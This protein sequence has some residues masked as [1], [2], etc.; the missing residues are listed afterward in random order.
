MRL[1][2]SWL[3]V[4]FVANSFH[5]AL[6][7]DD[8]STSAD[9]GSTAVRTT[10]PMVTRSF[11]RPYCH[12]LRMT[13]SP[14]AMSMDAYQNLYKQWGLDER[15]DDFPAH[16]LCRPLLIT[17]LGVCLLLDT[18]RSNRDLDSSFHRRANSIE[19]V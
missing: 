18:T 6:A 2:T 12:D 10:S 11:A 19:L 16:S 14:L 15:P 5:I 9:R 8:K 4:V 3:A 7:E 13:S 17:A 1:L